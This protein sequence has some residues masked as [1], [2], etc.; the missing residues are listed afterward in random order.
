MFVCGGGTGG[1]GASISLQPVK[2]LPPLAPNI[3]NLG[4]PNIHN[5][6]TPVIHPGLVS[7]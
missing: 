6:P 3:L 7:V 5:L 4:L 2:S 1:E